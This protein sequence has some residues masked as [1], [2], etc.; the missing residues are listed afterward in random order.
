MNYVEEKNTGN[1]N[2][3]RYIEEFAKLNNIQINNLEYGDVDGKIIY[4]FDVDKKGIRI[5]FDDE[6]IA[7]CANDESV[8]RLLKGRVENKIKSVMR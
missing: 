2:I 6:E 7:D 5:E 3:K 4:R 1:N 8:Q